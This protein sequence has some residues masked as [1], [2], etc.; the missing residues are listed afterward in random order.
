MMEHNASILPI[1][2]KAIQLAIAPK[3]GRTWRDRLAELDR[4]IDR[5]DEQIR[6]QPAVPA[7][8]RDDFREEID[9]LTLENMQLTAKLDETAAALCR[10]K[11]AYKEAVQNNSVLAHR[12]EDLERRLANVLRTGAIR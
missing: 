5:V 2:E 10:A 12:L 9:A 11:T 4:A 8:L 7:E 3:S 1:L 6:K